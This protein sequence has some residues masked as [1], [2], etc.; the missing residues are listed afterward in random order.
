MCNLQKNFSCYFK[1]TVVG[2]LFQQMLG[3]KLDI[4]KEMCK[5]NKVSFYNITNIR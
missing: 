5:K 2:Y 4:S 1:K 3:Y